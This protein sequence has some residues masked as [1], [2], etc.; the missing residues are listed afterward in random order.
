MSLGGGDRR[1]CCSILREGLSGCSA[2]KWVP[3]FISNCVE[4]AKEALAGHQRKQYED[5]SSC[6]TQYVLE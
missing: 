3:I 5:S 1:V 2:F 6:F 4:I